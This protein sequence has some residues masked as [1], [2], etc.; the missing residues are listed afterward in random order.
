MEVFS[1]PPVLRTLNISGSRTVT[2]ARG[3]HANQSKKLHLGC[4]A[5]T[6]TDSAGQPIPLGRGAVLR[7]LGCTLCWQ[8]YDSIAAVLFDDQV[9]GKETAEKAR[10][11]QAQVLSPDSLTFGNAWMDA[12]N[13]FEFHPMQE[14]ALLSLRVRMFADRYGEPPQPFES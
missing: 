1:I 8:D 13:L 7:V 14:V 12:L 2:V 3:R 4:S 5:Y 11:Y 10:A 9:V 6:E